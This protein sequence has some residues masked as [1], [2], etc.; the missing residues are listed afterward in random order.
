MPNANMSTYSEA[1]ILKY[2]SEEGRTTDYELKIKNE[3]EL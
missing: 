2:P 1:N 3:E